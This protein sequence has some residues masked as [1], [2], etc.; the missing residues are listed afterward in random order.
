MHATRGGQIVTCNAVI[1]AALA[2][3][4]F[5][6]QLDGGH[7]ATIRPSGRMQLSHIMLVVGDQVVVEFSAGCFSTGRIVHRFN[8][9][10][11]VPRP[12]H[13]RDG[14][15]SFQVLLAST[16]RTG[17][18]PRER[19]ATLSIGEPSLT[20]RVARSIAM[21]KHLA[22]TAALLVHRLRKAVRGRWA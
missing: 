9:E 20:A 11:S 1:V 19:G 6:V 7:H 15:R 2:A 18:R 5:R 8:G 4:N 21:I 22:L 3:S 17:V 16:V 14:F 12:R 10:V 13:R